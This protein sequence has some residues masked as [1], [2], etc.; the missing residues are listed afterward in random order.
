[1]RRCGM[2]SADRFITIDVPGASATRAFGIN[3]GGDVVGSY[4]ASGKT[5]GFIASATRQHR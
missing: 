3:A 4:V 2:R 5:Y 1:M